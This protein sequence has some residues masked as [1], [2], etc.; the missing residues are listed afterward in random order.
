NVGFAVLNLTDLE[1]IDKYVRQMQDE[2]ERVL[3]DAMIRVSR[4]FL[5]PTDP[6]VIQ[7][8]VK[9]PDARHIVEMADR[10]S[11]LLADQPGFNYVWTDWLNPSSKLVLDVDE[12]RA[13]LAGLSRLDIAQQVSVLTAGQTA[14]HIYQGDEKIPVIIRAVDAQSRSKD[15]LDSLTLYA[16]GSSEPVRLGTVADIRLEGQ[17]ARIN[18]EN[19][20]RAVTVESSNIKTSPEDL[21]V[22]LQKEIDALRKELQPG[23]IIEFDGA[24]GDSGESQGALASQ[25]PLA[26]G[27]II[28]LLLAQFGSF[29]NVGII[30][31]ILPL[32]VIGAAIGLKVMS[33][34]FGFMVILGLFALF[35]IV[36][37]NAIVLIDR[38]KIELKAAEDDADDDNEAEADNYESRR[39][40]LISACKRRLR[41][42]LITTITT[43]LGL[44]PLIIGKDVL[45]Y[46]LAN[47]V[48]FGLAVGTILTL[49]VVP[50]LYSLF[51]GINKAKS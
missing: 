46:G 41:P 5:G 6:N 13:K 50:V 31:L 21:V 33:A 28:I 42:I 43:I 2:L 32:S 9:G 26:L 23:H 17:Y 38:I 14:T 48:A 11:N 24:V 44:L 7:I 15:Y 4:M 10:L 29:R 30:L 3:P 39:A 40:A 18:R 27:L 12:S 36:V 20:E 8:Q 34:P 16:P 45:F 49:G 47:V 37:N 1:N 25:A 22:I 51:F 19:L 35:G